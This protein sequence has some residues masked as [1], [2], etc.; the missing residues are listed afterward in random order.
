MCLCVCL[1]VWA[2]YH[3]VALSRRER[4]LR[5]VRRLG[6]PQALLVADGSA[7]PGRRAALWL[8]V[9]WSSSAALARARSWQ[10]CVCV[11]VSCQAIPWDAPGRPMSGGVQLASGRPMS[12]VARLRSLAMASNERRQAAGGRSSV[13]GG[14]PAGAARQHVVA[15]VRG[16]P[17][18]M[19]WCVAAGQRFAKGAGGAC[20]AV[21]ARETGARTRACTK[22]L[23]RWSA[24]RARAVGVHLS[25]RGA[26]RVTRRLW[27]S[28]SGC[29]LSQAGLRAE[30]QKHRG[31][32][33]VAGAPSSSGAVAHMRASFV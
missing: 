6:D 25:T 2:C 24:A 23:V 28:R 11:C 16:R 29:V 7:A 5:W 1:C 22:L 31:A 8:R 15:P 13:A 19:W 14:R 33:V 26:P 17:G 32:S 20:Q 18:S 4:S 27:A 9:T 21:G 3:L 10:K 30:R 12:N